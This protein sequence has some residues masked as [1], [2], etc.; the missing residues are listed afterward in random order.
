MDER[1]HNLQEIREAGGQG[2]LAS[3]FIAIDEA[4][5]VASRE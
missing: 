4:A 3:G 5:E 2:K 1:G